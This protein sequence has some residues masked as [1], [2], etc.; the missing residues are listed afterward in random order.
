MRC[1]SRIKAWLKRPG[2]DNLKYE[3]C[4]TVLI[5]SLSRYVNL[6]P[7]ILK[8]LTPRSLRKRPT[9]GDA[10]TGFFAKWRLRNERRNS[11]LMRHYQDLGSA[12]AWLN[13]ISHA[14][15]PIRSTTLIWVVTRISA[16]VSQTSFSGETS[17]SALEGGRWAL[18]YFLGGYVTPGTPNWHPVLIKI[19]P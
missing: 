16:L 7:G 18:G 10:T 12:S 19:S 5:S 9:F 2:K 17:G 6:C 13:Q 11:V 1:S 15:R 8:S 14:A 3:L 4:D